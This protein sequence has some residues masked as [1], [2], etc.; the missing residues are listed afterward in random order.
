[1]L[2]DFFGKGGTIGKWELPRPAFDAIEAWL[3]AQAEALRDVR[4]RFSLA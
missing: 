4:C 2:H 3:A 1:M